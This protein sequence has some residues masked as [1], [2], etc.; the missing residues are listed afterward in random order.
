MIIILNIFKVITDAIKYFARTIN[1]F[2]DF[3][4]AEFDHAYDRRQ[5]RKK[6]REQRG[7]ARDER[8][9]AERWFQRG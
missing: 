5:E 4:I 3:M 9:L 2:I 1:N 7:Y 8:S 6:I